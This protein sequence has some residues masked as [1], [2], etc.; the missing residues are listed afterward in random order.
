MSGTRSS[1]MVVLAG[2]LVFAV[3]ACTAL[4]LPHRQP[5]PI[6]VASQFLEL[7]HAGQ[8]PSAHGMTVGTAEVGNSPSELERIARGQL[9][10]SLRVAGTFPRQSNGNRV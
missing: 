4:L 9:C 7:L 8:Y 2:V 6:R 1:R 5:V 3:L 10:P